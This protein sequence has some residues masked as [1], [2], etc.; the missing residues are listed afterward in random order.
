M[1]RLQG[2]KIEKK[3]VWITLGFGLFEWIFF[4]QL[5]VVSVMRGSPDEDSCFE[6]SMKKWKSSCSVKSCK[7][8]IGLNI[9]C[10]L[11]C[12]IT[13]V[14]YQSSF[15]LHWTTNPVKTELK[16]LMMNISKTK[17]V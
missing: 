17:I 15:I 7:M 9:G 4:E 3:Q 2:F 8:D 14:E 5:G 10:I 12:K 11:W 16:L 6:V 13:P 1:L